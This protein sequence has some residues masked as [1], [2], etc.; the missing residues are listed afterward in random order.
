M[1][2]KVNGCC[3]DTFN[4]L[5]LATIRLAKAGSSSE[6]G[7]KTCLGLPLETHLM[8]CAKVIT[9]LYESYISP[10]VRRLLAGNSNDEQT[11]AFLRFIAAFHDAGKD[12][13]DFQNR[14]HQKFGFEQQSTENKRLS[15]AKE[16]DMIFRICS[17]KHF[18]AVASLLNGHHRKPS[19]NQPTKTDIRKL[20][21]VCSEAGSE[22]ADY[23]QEWL[24]YYKNAI[25][26]SG[27]DEKSLPNL[28]AL[29]IEAGLLILADWIASDSEY[30]PYL[31]AAEMIADKQ[32]N[33]EEAI[34]KD[35]VKRGA[36]LKQQIRLGGQWEPQPEEICQE[37]YQKRFGEKII[38]HP[39]QKLAYEAAQSMDKPGLMIIEAEMG[40]GK[41]EMGLAAAEIFAKKFGMNGLFFGLPTQATSN[42]LFRR[43]S[44]WFEQQR[45]CNFSE[46]LTMNLVHQKAKYNPDFLRM[47]RLSEDGEELSVLVDSWYERRH[48]EMFPN[49][50]IGT[51]DHLLMMA[52]Q[53]RNVFFYHLALANKVVIVD[54]VHSLDE[55]SLQYLKIALRYLGSYQVPVILLSASLG[56]TYRH[57]LIKAY[58][59]S[60]YKS[61]KQRKSTCKEKHFSIVEAER[62]NFTENSHTALGLPGDMTEDSEDGGKRARNSN[63]MDQI[64]FVHDYSG[65]NEESLLNNSRNTPLISWT[66]ETDVWYLPA[67][68]ENKPEKEITLISIREDEA[69][70]K[71]GEFLVDGAVIGVI[72]NTVKKAQELYQKLSAA[73]GSEN[74]EADVFLLHSRFTNLDRSSKEKMLEKVA[75][76][77][78][79]K[80][81]RPQIVIGTQVLEES[82]DLDFDVLFS[83]SCKVES[84]IQRT[85]RLFRHIR[86]RP[87]GISSPVCYVITDELNPDSNVK[88]YQPWDVY[89]MQQT[90]PKS[91]FVPSGISAW[92]KEVELYKPDEQWAAGKRQAENEKN[93]NSNSA[94]PGLI[95]VLYPRTQPDLYG[96]LKNESLD[97]SVRLGII[98]IECLLLF[99]DGNTIWLDPV[100]GNGISADCI[101]DPGKLPDFIANSIRLPESLMRYKSSLEKAFKDNRRRFEKWTDFLEKYHLNVLWLDRQGMDENDK[102]RFTYSKEEGFLY[103]WNSDLK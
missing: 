82:L 54:E 44:S 58:Q 79:I 103:L 90:M 88:P 37:Y 18:T 94:V 49:F 32:R 16:S 5:D 66:Q 100:S 35:D 20:K 14:L 83:Q 63:F 1:N 12:L 26:F 21:R 23:E 13:P 68:M 65:A 6:S 22:W 57:E 67:P 97:F 75:G 91:F 56:S 7:D 28:E 30:F 80:Q 9:F 17:G 4:A 52:L 71:I 99:T 59:D 78:R 70:S 39:E 2:E 19:L 46:P 64:H 87:D 41:T 98:P 77:N 74:G 34:W 85:G 86:P 33:G 25:K 50:V 76:K 42:G 27:W 51:Y 73:Y 101:P 95:K 102:L 45:S 31:T 93:S 92:I 72:V 10:H 53:N 89:R 38:P 84:F 62:K 81:E 36:D 11:L 40:K 43:V 29:G 69:V 3:A 96:F 55:Y 24:R 47:K 8:D 48:M 60:W 61:K 15:H